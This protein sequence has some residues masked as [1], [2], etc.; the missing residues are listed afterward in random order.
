MAGKE[1]YRN[2]AINFESEE[3]RFVL[4]E[5]KKPVSMMVKERKDAHLLI[6]DFM[7]LANKSVAKFVS[8][9]TSP[10]V[11]YVYRIHDL[12]Y[13]AKLT[14]F[15]LFAKEMGYTMKL[16]SP[17]NIAESFNSLAKKIEQDATLRILSPLA[18]RT[19]AKAEYST[20]NIGHYG[21][22]FEYYSHFT[23]PIRRYSDVLAHRILFEN[24]GDAIYRVDQESLEQKCKHISRQEVKA[25][26]AERRKS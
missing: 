16:D 22:A 4:D 1:R 7:L 6:E 9:K 23:S 17:K 13:P 24:L 25:A 5:N 12:P 20:K 14:D 26:E 11:P 21:L 8:K 18:I 19:M 10:Q 2:G 15:A 3:V